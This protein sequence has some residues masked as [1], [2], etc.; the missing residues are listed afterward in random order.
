MPGA[1]VPVHVEHGVR[2]EQ[3]AQQHGVLRRD[4]GEVV[5]DE[6]RRPDVARGEA[7]DAPGIEPEDLGLG[8]RGA[9]GDGGAQRVD[10]TGE[11]GVVVRVVTAPHDATG[12]DEGGQHRQGA[13]VDLEADGA[14]AGEVLGRAQRQVGAEAAEG[15]GLLVEALEPEGGPPAAGLEEDAAQARMALEHPEG[16]Q[17]GAGEH[18]LERVGD[19]V[20]DERVERAVRPQRGHDDRAALVDADG[21]VEL[22]RGVPHRVVG[23]VGQRAA[24]A[25]VGADEPRHEAELG[26]GPAQLPRRRVGVLQGEQRRPEEPAWVGG[27]VAGQPVVVRR[28][29]P[30]RGGRVVDGGEVQPDGRVQDRLVDALGVHVTQS[31][32]GVRPAGEGVGQRAEQGGVVE[33]RARAGQAAQGHGQDLGGADDDVL[34]AGRVRADAWPRPFRQ[35]RPGLGGLDHVAVGVD[36]GAGAGRE[37]GVRHG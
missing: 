25:G 14:L 17:L 32:A 35:P 5:T 31:G 21:H 34:V 20:Q 11:G 23:A 36:D 9:G 12:P 18:L 4:G 37:G 2:R 1:A 30:D 27:A 24:E 3:R 19:G 29:Q 8:G 10:G 7:V 26:H 13:L 28:G 6:C 33:G 15:L 22:L 16:D